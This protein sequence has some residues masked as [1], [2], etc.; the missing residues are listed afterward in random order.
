ME[1]S[2]IAPPTGQSTVRVLAYVLVLMTV[3]T[4][5]MTYPQVFMLSDG[6]PDVGDPLLNTWALAWV[7]HQL[8]IAP[9]RLFDA[10]IFFPERAALAYSETLLLP[11]LMAAPL[12]WLGLGPILVY[13]L[14]FLSAIVFSGL[15]M[16]VLVRDLTRNT[17]AGVIAG[18]VFAFL[19]F[20]I[21]HISHLQMQL[22]Q[23]I[24]LTMWALHRLIRSGRWWDGALLGAFAACQMLSCAYFGVFLLPYVAVVTVVLLLAQCRLAAT[25][26]TVTV[27]FDRVFVTRRLL[28]LALAAATY[29]ALAAPTGLAYRR[30]SAVVGERSAGEVVAGSAM[31]R[32]YLATGSKNALYGRWSETFGEAERRL[33]PGVVAFALALVGL[34]RP[35]SAA[36]IAYGVA[37]LLAFDMSLGFNGLTYRFLWNN[38]FLFRGLRI[39]ARMGLFVG[40]SLAVLAGY[41]VARMMSLITL[42][43]RRRALA[44]GLALL[45]LV[46]FRSKPLGLS[47]VPTEP[48]AVYADLLRDRGDSPRSTILEWPIARADPTFMYYSTFHWENLLNGYSGFFSPAYFNLLTTLERFPDTSVLEALWSRRTRYVVIH[49]EILPEAEYTGLI[50]AVDAQPYFELVSRRPWLGREVSLYRL[51]PEAR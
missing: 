28:V 51:R 50:A 17:S 37:L 9:A 13:N 35:R 16:T 45:V 12:H 20:R 18:I 10:N 25:G 33:F 39:P 46:E 1:P 27:S 34:R 5:V 32:H 43:G 4:A 15:G 38:V 23:W 26:E 14:V 47:P 29:A 3:L 31:P 24:P 6:L 11:G 19:P 21:D 48:P 7:A 22:T 49:G 44:V 36:Q 2:R 30:A 40:F 42:P 8:P 41:G